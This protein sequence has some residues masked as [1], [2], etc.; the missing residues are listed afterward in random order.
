MT[1]LELEKHMPRMRYLRQNHEKVS[2]LLDDIKQRISAK[3][4]PVRLACPVCDT[5]W[6]SFHVMWNGNLRVVC[7]AQDCIAYMAKMEEQ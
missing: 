2:A 7:N 3:Q 5:G 4:R 6:V 1:L